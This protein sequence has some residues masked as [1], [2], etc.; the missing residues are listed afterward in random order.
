MLN[1]ARMCLD[2][3][4]AP[5]E[6]EDIDCTTNA[7]CA[8]G[9]LCVW[10]EDAP[11]HFD[12][13][14]RGPLGNQ[15]PQ[16]SC[17]SGLNCQN[18]VCTPGINIGGA[19][20]RYTCSRHNQCPGGFTCSYVDYPGQSYTQSVKACLPVAAANVCGV[21]GDCSGGNICGV[22]P[23]GANSWANACAPP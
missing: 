17:S 15:Q 12:Q 10:V 22:H 3:T 13:Q 5:A 18:G 19:L 16:T 8:Q 1:G 23:D 11:G 9:T 21:D 7:D 20:C 2:P 6:A 4:T 14:C